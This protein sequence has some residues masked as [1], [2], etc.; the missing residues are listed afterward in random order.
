MLS[1]LFL[2]RVNYKLSARSAVNSTRNDVC[3]R[4]FEL[5]TLKVTV[6]VMDSDCLGVYERGTSD[7]INCDGMSPTPLVK[8][9]PTKRLFK[10]CFCSNLTYQLLACKGIINLLG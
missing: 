2:V 10:I 1:V 9:R 4:N 7:L 8:G 3:V 5:T 6:I